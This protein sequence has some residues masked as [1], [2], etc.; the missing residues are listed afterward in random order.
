MQT[1]LYPQTLPPGYAFDLFFPV[2]ALPPWNP[3][4]GEAMGISILVNDND[5]DYRKRAAQLNAGEEPMGRPGIWPL[6][7]LEEGL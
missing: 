6:M 5:G 2:E 3:K 7:V 4:A 1:R